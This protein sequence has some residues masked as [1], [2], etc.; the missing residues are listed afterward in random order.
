MRTGVL[1]VV[2][3]EKVTPSVLADPTFSAVHLAVK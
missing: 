3:E 2:E 1:I